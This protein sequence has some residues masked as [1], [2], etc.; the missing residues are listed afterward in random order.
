MK[1]KTKNPIIILGL[2]LILFVIVLL[3]IYGGTS[4]RRPSFEPID[5]NST[6]SLEKKVKTLTIA[7]NRLQ[8]RFEKFRQN[9]YGTESIQRQ[10]DKKNIEQLQRDTGKPFIS[11][12][13][14]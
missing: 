2:I 13:D 9:Y 14:K 12:S 8:A 5:P 10:T 4:P 3:P 6:E 7:F 1:Q 11:N